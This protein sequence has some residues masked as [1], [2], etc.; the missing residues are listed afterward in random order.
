MGIAVGVVLAQEKVLFTSDQ[1]FEVSDEVIGEI[2]STKIDLELVED[3]SQIGWGD[4]LGGI[5]SES[6]EP[7]TDWV[8]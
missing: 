1:N 5:D 8:K 2:T 7:D 4:M 3:S 6:R